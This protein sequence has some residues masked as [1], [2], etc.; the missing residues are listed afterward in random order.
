M[1]KIN[2]KKYEFINPKKNI[3][4]ALFYLPVLKSN[5]D[6]VSNLY[7]DIRNT[8]YAGCMYIPNLIAEKNDL[9]LFNQILEEININFKSDDNSTLVNWSK[10]YKIENP[11]SLSPTFQKIVNELASFFKI[12]VLAT[13]LNYYTDADFKPFH[14]DSHAYSNGIKEDI[15]IGCSLGSTRSLSFKHVESGRFFEFPQHNGDIFSFDHETNKKFQHGVPK[16]RKSDPDNIR[17]S[18]IIWGKKN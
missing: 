1:T 9:K 2:S 15:T 17:I 14:H 10:H 8:L 16:L 5:F 7:S 11:D 18:I 13:R 12:T 4:N 6:M 3:N